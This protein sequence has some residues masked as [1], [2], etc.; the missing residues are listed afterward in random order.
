M[1]DDHPARKFY[2]SSIVCASGA[3]SVAECLF[4]NLVHHYYRLEEDGGKHDHDFHKLAKN[5]EFADTKLK[6]GETNLQA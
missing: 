4:A 2:A 1:P 6:V 5:L 3:G